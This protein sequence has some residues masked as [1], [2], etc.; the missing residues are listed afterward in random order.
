MIASLSVPPDDN[1]GYTTSMIV[2]AP[3]AKPFLFVG[4]FGPARLV[5]LLT[6]GLQHLGGARAPLVRC[7][8]SWLS[9]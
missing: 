4:D 6:L 8:P 5:F 1:V 2:D 9:V 3:T 7:L